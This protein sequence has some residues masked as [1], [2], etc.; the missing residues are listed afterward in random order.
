MDTEKENKVR[1]I[2]EEKVPST[3]GSQMLLKRTRSIQGVKQGKRLPLASKDNNNNRSSSFLL[4]KNKN[5]A[6]LNNN[7]V[8]KFKKY[9]SV[10]GYDTGSRV[11]SLVLKDIDSGDEK[12][13]EEDDDD[14]NPLAL[15]LKQALDGEKRVDL[16]KKEIASTGLLSGKKGLRQIFNDRDYDREIEIAP[17]KPQEKEYIP[18]GYEP[19]TKEEIRSLHNFKNSYEIQVSDD[20]NSEEEPQPLK[21]IP[22]VNELDEEDLIPTKSLKIAENRSKVDDEESIELDTIYDGRGLSENDLLDLLD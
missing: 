14:E 5:K 8:R 3:P 19:F 2:L 6:V 18:D 15:K 21:L 13:N 10:L 1:N 20:E 22:L 17:E 4:P 11:K 9:G 12:S 7:N 16:S